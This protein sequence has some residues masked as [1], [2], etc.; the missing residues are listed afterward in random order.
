[1]NFDIKAHLQNHA[2]YFKQYKEISKNDLH[3][4]F[5]F[6]DIQ[7]FNKDK[8]P[9]Q[10]L[11]ELLQEL[12]KP[13][14]Y[15][16]KN[17]YYIDKEGNK[18]Q[19][20]TTR[21]IN[22]A[23]A[24]KIEAIHT[25]GAEGEYTMPHIHF[26]LDKNARLGKNFSLLKTHIIEISKK[27]GLKP[28][29]AEIS[30]ENPNTYRNLGKSVK[31]FSWIIRKMPNK[32]FK[33]YVSEKLEDKL[34]KLWE[35]SLL[36]GNLQYYVKTLE[37]IKKR[38]NRQKIDFKWKDHNIRN[39]YPIPLTQN[40]LEVIKLINE[41]K[42]SQKDIKPYL[43]NAILRDFVRYSYFKDK[44]KALIINSL[45]KE[46]K[47]FQNLRPNK[48]IVE[49]Y[50]KL[51]QKTLNLDKQ[52]LIKEQQKEKHIKSIKEILKEDLLKVAKTCINE[53]ELRQK[54]Q[55]LGY[56]EFGFKKKGGKVI[57]YQFKLP[58]EDKKIVIKCSDSI[59]IKEI[60]AYLKDNWI[61]FQQNKP[62]TSDLSKENSLINTYTLPKPFEPPKPILV[63][64]KTKEIELQKE[65]QK[66]NS[67]KQYQIIK[68]NLQKS[69][70][71]YQIAKELNNQAT[72]ELNIQVQN[73]MHLNI[74]L[75]KISLKQKLLKEIKNARKTLSTIRD[76]I[77]TIKRYTKTINYL[78]RRKL[79]IEKESPNIRREI[80]FYRERITKTIR[81][82]IERY[83]NKFKQSIT[84][85]LTRIKN[86]LTLFNNQIN[87]ILN[88]TIKLKHL[89]KRE[90]TFE[91]VE[92]KKSIKLT[93]EFKS[94]FE[95]IEELKKEIIKLK[96]IKKDIPKYLSQLKQKKFELYNKIT[97]I[98]D[99][100]EYLLETDEQF[101]KL[102]NE[103]QAL[104]QE[105]EKIEKEIEKIE[106]MPEYQQKQLQQTYSTGF[107][108]KL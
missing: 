22:L 84:G 23:N 75:T 44:N 30:Q 81:D 14:Q 26:I 76:N 78:S 93:D 88:N 104:L 17:G 107:R 86:N 31:N 82:T 45:S 62:I 47:L 15:K 19:K 16:V 94:T 97:K 29:F 57:G 67:Q 60:R 38:L 77:R 100:Q 73:Q 8:T 99:E 59:D 90:L 64:Y 1:M 35:Y 43:N 61:K 105:V 80:E 58:N 91:P 63:P 9:E 54:M 102:E 106:K 55:E 101:I 87:E 13:A 103:R 50:L 41:K 5:S 71:I 79:T 56:K 12:R 11:L 98:E 36:S 20:F 32:D 48:K 39:T 18:R 66:K 52:Q 10:I 83:R 3:F 108:R 65:K 2:F 21:E 33:K 89:S 92:I 24:I 53:K 69:E 40:D 25:Q 68:N 49:N 95:K 6:L 96:E 27:Y 85:T 37:F 28:N 4:N 72:K 70:K 7:F 34:N 74:K 42:F 46:T 51:Y